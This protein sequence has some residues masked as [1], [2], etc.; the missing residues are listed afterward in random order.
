[1]MKFSRLDVTPFDGVSI[2]RSP[3]RRHW[4]TL[5]VCKLKACLFSIHWLFHRKRTHTSWH[6]KIPPSVLHLLA[7][8]ISYT[9]SSLLLLI[10]RLFLNFLLVVLFP[11]I[12]CLFFLFSQYSHPFLSLCLRHEPF[13]FYILPFYSSSHPSRPLALLPLIPSS[14]P[15]PI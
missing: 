5:N 6:F 7:L 15:S 3:Y 4:I 9:I 10:L 1:M 14:Q 13:L 8:F 12:F 11:F 2:P